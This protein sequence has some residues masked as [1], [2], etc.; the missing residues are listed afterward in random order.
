[1]AAQTTTDIIKAN[2]EKVSED[3][4]ELFDKAPTGGTTYE[5]LK[6]VAKDNP[7]VETESGKD[8][9]LPF[10]KQKAGVY[11]TFSRDGGSLGS[12]SG[13]VI[14]QFYQTFFDTKLAISIDL[15]AI[16]NTKGSQSVIDAWKMNMKDAIP[17][18]KT[19][20]ASGFHNLSSG[21]QGLVALCTAATAPSG[22]ASTLTF[23]TEYSGNLLQVGQKVEIF[24]NDLV[25]HRTTGLTEANLPYISSIS[26]EAGTAVVSGLGAITPG[27]TD[28][29]AFPGVTAT[30]TWMH[31][32]HYFHRTSTSGSVLGVSATTVPEILPNKVNASGSLVPM[33]GELLRTRIRQRRG[34]LSK[35][36]GSIHDAQVAQIKATQISIMELSAEKANGMIDILPESGQFV[37]WAGVTHLVD[38]QQSK[39]RID[40]FDTSVWY[41]VFN[42]ELDFYKNPGNG[43]MIFEGR[44]SSGEVTASWHYFLWLSENFACGDPGRDGF[45]YNLS[46]PTDF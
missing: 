3:L 40:W 33:H 18:M 17:N 34:D 11:G 28:Y 10:K 45:I 43:Q 19:Y 13:A 41:R 6:K 24:S 32:K 25:T 15:G 44:N 35:V 31:G 42:K 1:M 37:K 8:F 2:M 23:D 39:K 38:L 14:D 30:P 36:K 20:S 21:N 22:A 9:R 26:R 29:L 12:G 27:N 7:I 16:Q 4:P 5:M 46:I